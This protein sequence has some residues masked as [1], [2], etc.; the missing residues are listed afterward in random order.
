MVSKVANFSIDLPTAEVAIQVSGS[1]GSRQEEAQRLGRLLRPK[2]EGKTA[3][4]YTIVSPRHRRRRV[5]RQ[6]A[7]VPGRAG[8]RLLDPRRGGLTD[9]RA[10]GLR[11]LRAGPRHHPERAGRARR[12][13]VR[14][15]GWSP[16]AGT[17]AVKQDLE[18]L[19]ADDVAA[20]EV[21]AEFHHRCWQSG[22]PTPEPLRSRAGD[23]VVRRSGE[24]VS[25][26]SWV[27][28]REPDPTIDPG[29]V[30]TLLAQLHAVPAPPQGAVH[31]WFE[32]PIGEPEWKAV[33]KASRAAGAPYVDRLAEVLPALVLVESILTPM[34][35]VQTCHLDLWSDNLD[36]PRPAICAS[37]TSTTPVRPTPR[38][39]SGCSCS[40]SG[41][42]TPPASTGCTTPTARLA[43]RGGSRVGPTSR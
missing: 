18:P 39:R 25:A 32:A 8:V 28:L 3:H 35:P 11:R 19:D 22:I 7:A 14:S 37:S 1:F 30:G 40:S 27:D 20:A 4:F 31:E 21:S 23:F 36:A 43:A 17:W 2:T 16:T 6:P 13:R 24:H 33:L 26:F 10:G 5:R 12:A 41:R 34:R 15:A 38:A 9:G 42:V 29:P